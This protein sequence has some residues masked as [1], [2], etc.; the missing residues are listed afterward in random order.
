MFKLIAIQFCVF[1]NKTIL[2]GKAL[3]TWTKK[4]EHTNVDTVNNNDWS[5]M[6]LPLN[7]TACHTVSICLVTKETMK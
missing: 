5:V 3:F 7:R 4:S 6:P 1:K 2:L